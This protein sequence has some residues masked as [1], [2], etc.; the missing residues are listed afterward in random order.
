MNKKTG[1]RLVVAFLLSTLISL[2]LLGGAASALAYPTGTPVGLSITDPTLCS[3]D[4]ATAMGT[5]FQPG[6]TVTL[7]FQG[8]SVATIVVDGEGNFTYTYQL[9]DNLEEGAYPVTAIGNLTATMATT[10]V[11]I[12]STGC[13]LTKAELD[14]L[15]AEAAAASAAALAASQKSNGLAFTGF[16]AASVGVVGLILIG[17]GLLLTVASRRR[18]DRG[19]HGIDS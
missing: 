15:A 6:E 14:R 16:Q 13:P 18:R 4:A 1:L 2:G 10:S 12:P 9:P 3:A 8:A 17:G 7:A 11:T 5:G 19:H